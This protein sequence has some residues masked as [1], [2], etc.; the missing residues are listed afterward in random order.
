[1]C[2]SRK[3]ISLR[4]VI[5]SEHLKDVLD[6]QIPDELDAAFSRSDETGLNVIKLFFFV[7]DDERPNKLECSCLANTFQSSQTFAGS[8]RSSP[9]KEAS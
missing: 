4:V 7:A 1:M 6:I 5:D 3:P 8:T 2:D 9:K